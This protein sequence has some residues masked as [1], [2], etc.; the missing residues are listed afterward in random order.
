MD[1]Y[2][3]FPDEASMKAAFGT[4]EDKTDHGTIVTHPVVA[5][6]AVDI[7]GLIYAPTGE[8]H[9]ILG[10]GGEE[11]DAPVMAPLEGWHVNLRGEALPEHLLAFVVEPQN[12][13]RVWA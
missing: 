8:T 2:L 4:T 11:I 10:P 9:K 5:H 6:M 13:A 1:Y 7:V 3:R 12:P